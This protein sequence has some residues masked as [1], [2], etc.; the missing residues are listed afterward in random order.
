MTFTPSE[1]GR[2]HES[3]RSS[4]SKID[5]QAFP[6]VTADKVKLIE[7][8][9]DVVQEYESWGYYQRAKSRNRRDGGEPVEEV[10]TSHLRITKQRNGNY[11]DDD[12]DTKRHSHS[13]GEENPTFRLKSAV[14]SSSA[15]CPV[16]T[17]KLDN[18]PV[19]P[20]AKALMVLLGIASSSP[21][22]IPPVS[23]PST[24][25]PVSPGVNMSTHPDL[26]NPLATS[27]NIKSPAKSSQSTSKLPTKESGDI[28]L[29]V[30]RAFPV[31][32]VRVEIPVPN[33]IRI[34]RPPPPPQQRKFHFFEPEPTCY[35][36]NKECKSEVLH[37]DT[38][39]KRM[40]RQICLWSTCDAILGS[41]WQL[42]HHLERAHLSSALLEKVRPDEVDAWKCQWNDCGGLYR[43]RQDLMQHLLNAHFAKALRC[44][45]TTCPHPDKVY[46]NVATLENH[47]ARQDEVHVR[48]LVNPLVDLSV[49]RSKPFEDRTIPATVK[50]IDLLP[51]RVY[52]AIWSNAR[53]KCHVIDLVQESSFADR[54]DIRMRAGETPPPIDKPMPKIE[55][56]QQDTI[57]HQHI[58]E[59]EVV[60][61]IDRPVRRGI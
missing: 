42:H 57:R 54:E 3:N 36:F 22:S 33:R 26:T 53:R 4:K 48:T 38:L 27:H 1:G 12:G 25:V 31:D 20:P 52:P 24:S 41:E 44:P 18:S 17:A 59:V 50:Q 5:G 9:T 21:V 8:D 13:H 40:C 45:Y 61:G 11:V 51:I 29:K 19:L 35:R 10:D 58:Q 16:E 30:L 55:P 43:S 2:K 15:S 34:P 32:R 37:K 46:P 23:S 28:N 49:S 56:I 39:L 14:T 7:V 60:I 6:A 47:I